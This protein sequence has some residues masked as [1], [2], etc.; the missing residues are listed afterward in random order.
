MKEPLLSSSPAPYET[1]FALHPYGVHEHA[2][3]Y[4]YRI[5]S[6]SSAST[7]SLPHAHPHSHSTANITEEHRPN[8]RPGNLWIDTTRA[9]EDAE[10]G[11][12]DLMK[13]FTLPQEGETAWEVGKG[14]DLA[15]EIMGQQRR[16]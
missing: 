10:L 11:N 3:D 5:S 6:A 4:P 8:L 14:K 16:Q 7:S 2:S 13:A 12:A 9:S 15:R 1:E